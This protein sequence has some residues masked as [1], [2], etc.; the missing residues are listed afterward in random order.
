M[1]ESVAFILR[2]KFP[3]IHFTFCQDDDVCSGQP[4]F[5]SDS[6]KLY[7]IDGSNHCLSFTQDMKEATGIVV[8]ET[9]DE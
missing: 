1:S 4:V 3:E 9:N 6:F 7:L 8:A 2:E 5:S